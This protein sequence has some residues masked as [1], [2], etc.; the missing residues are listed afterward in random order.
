MSVFTFMKLN[1]FHRS[2]AIVFLLKY[3]IY[4]LDYLEEV[5]ENEMNFIL[6]LIIMIYHR[7]CI[8]SASIL[9]ILL[10]KYNVIK[11]LGQNIGFKIE[12]II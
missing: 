2:N 10:N 8:V 3:F 12:T 6:S 9:L 1:Y 4:Y 5:I 11:D 7:K